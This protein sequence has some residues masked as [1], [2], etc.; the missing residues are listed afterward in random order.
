MP[1][2]LRRPSLP[3]LMTAVTTIQEEE[4][5]PVLSYPMSA[6][7]T[8]SSPF[9]LRSSHSPVT[10]TIPITTTTTTTTTTSTTTETSYRR[11]HRR[12]QSL[13]FNKTPLTVSTKPASTMIPTTA[14]TTNDMD[15]TIADL[16]V[17]PVGFSDAS[18]EERD[19]NDS[20]VDEMRTVVHV[21]KKVSL[22][23][24]RSFCWNQSC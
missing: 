1:A 12:L 8:R 2:A 3:L 13:L 17:S 15:D 6:S 18:D 5:S 21:A 14:M 9:S 7:T 19:D 16:E 4:E 24:G 20:E 22:Y 10:P 23:R 11:R